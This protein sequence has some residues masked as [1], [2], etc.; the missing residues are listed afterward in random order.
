MITR[1]W[2]AL[3]AY[4]WFRGTL[5]LYETY[6]SRMVASEHCNVEFCLANK[7][8]SSVYERHTIGA[9]LTL[10]VVCPHTACMLCLLV[11]EFGVSDGI[12]IMLYPRH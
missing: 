4:A 9:R 3:L 6:C 1:G 11:P 8:T 12:G 2:D 7:I 10:H 5:D